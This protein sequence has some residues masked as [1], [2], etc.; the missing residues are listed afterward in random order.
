[1]RTL[2]QR[3]NSGTA[4]LYRHFD[5]RADLIA[6]VVDTMF[7]AIELDVAALSTLFWQDACKAACHRMFDVLRRHRNVASLL[8]DDVP[9]GPNAL[10]TREQTLAFLL[11]NGFP[12][13]LAARSYATLARYILGFAMQLNGDH[14]DAKLSQTFRDLD[15][16]QCPAIAAVADHLPVPWEDEFAFGLDLLIEGLAQALQRAQSHGANV[17]R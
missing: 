5:G 16:T 12:P 11:H 1:M 14:D 6:S 8:A 17:K 10:A 3:L 7:G 13:A 4:T 15:P 2:A 9:L